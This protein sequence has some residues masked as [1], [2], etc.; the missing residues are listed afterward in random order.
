VDRVDLV[1]D[2]CRLARCRIEDGNQFAA[3]EEGSIGLPEI[4]IA[5][6][7]GSDAGLEILQSIRSR[8]NS[9]LPVERAIGIAGIDAEAEI[10]EFCRDVGIATAERYDN[11]VAV[12]FDGLYRG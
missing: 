10:G 12:S 11:V 1:G 3:I 9:L 7:H 5:L 8:A 2:K 6:E 4:G